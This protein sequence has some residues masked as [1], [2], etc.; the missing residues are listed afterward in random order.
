MDKDYFDIKNE[1]FFDFLNETFNLRK[2]KTWDEVSK[3]VT[4]EKVKKTY[5]TFAQLFPLK[6]DYST[7]LEKSKNLFSTIHYN[8]LK[9]RK[10]IDE[11]VRFSMYSDKIIVFHPLQ[12]P[13]VTNH[14]LDP[15][16]NPRYWLPDFLEALY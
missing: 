1:Y 15:R 12:N 9:G 4:I 8:D 16:K 3:N 7:E 14:K 13:T 10:I 11:V 2:S 6:Y 5:K